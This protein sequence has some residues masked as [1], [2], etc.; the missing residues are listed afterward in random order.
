MNYND[1]VHRDPLNPPAD[2]P[3]YPMTR[4]TSYTGW[5]VG[6]LLGLVLVIGIVFAFSRTEGK[7]TASDAN[8]PA[9]A[10]TGSGSTVPLLGSGHGTA[11]NVKQT[12]PP[13][14]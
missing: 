14:P 10:T 5:I 9:P 7:R 6:G 1:P 11:G 2:R 4:P 8:R 12:V 13:P 3:S